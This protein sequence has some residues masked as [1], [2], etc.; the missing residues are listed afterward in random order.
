MPKIT[1]RIKPRF[2]F[3]SMFLETVIN[4]NPKLNKRMKLATNWAMMI[5]TVFD[6]EQ[7]VNRSFFVQ[8]IVL[9]IS[10]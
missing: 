5:T 2:E 4:H 10:G 7:E 6:G 3:G 9:G 8:V 1:Q